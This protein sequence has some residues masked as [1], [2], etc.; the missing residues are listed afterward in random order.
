[1]ADGDLARLLI[2]DLEAKGPDSETGK[3]PTAW[4]ELQH[5]LN[6]GHFFEADIM[7]HNV[8]AHG[9]VTATIECGHFGLLRKGVAHPDYL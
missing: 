8:E 9:R 2:I 1:M 5:A 3:L 7:A 4:S 6:A